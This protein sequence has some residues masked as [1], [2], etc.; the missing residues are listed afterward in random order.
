MTELE[1]CDNEI[2]HVSHYYAPATPTLMV[3]CSPLWIGVRS[4]GY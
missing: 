1:R 4:V 3:Y 2:R